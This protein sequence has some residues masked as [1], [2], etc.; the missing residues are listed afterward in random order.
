M[1]RSLSQWPAAS[2]KIKRKKLFKIIQCQHRMAVKGEGGH[3][4]REGPARELTTC[5]C[6]CTIFCCTGS[7]TSILSCND[8]NMR[9]KGISLVSEAW[10]SPVDTRLR[11]W[12]PLQ[13]RRT[14]IVVYGCNHVLPWNIVLMHIH[15]SHFIKLRFLRTRFTCLFSML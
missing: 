14:V 1:T 3:F 11:I 4:C 6:T 12:A 15:A 13:I 2:C 5:T 10:P 7:S 9:C 8:K